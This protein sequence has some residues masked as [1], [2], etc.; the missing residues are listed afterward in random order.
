MSSLPK[1]TQGTGYRIY[2]SVLNK[3][4]VNKIFTH[5]TLEICFFA[6]GDHTSSFIEKLGMDTTRLI[7]DSHYRKDLGVL[8][9]VIRRKGN[10]RESK[11]LKKSG[12]TS[13]YLSVHIRDLIRRN[14]LVYNIFKELYGTYK[15]AFTNGLDYLIFKPLGTEDSP[16]ILNCKIFEPLEVATSLNNP[17]HYVCFVVISSNSN[18]GE[19]CGQLH[20]LLNFDLYYELIQQI[21]CP[22]GK[23]PI[24]KQKKN[25]EVSLLENFNLKMINKELERII[26][27]NPL[28][29]EFQPLRWVTVP[30]KNG[31]VLIFDCRIPYMTS[32][33]KHKH[34]TMYVP[35]SLRPVDNNWYSSNK[36]KELVNGIQNGKVGNWNKRTFKSCNIDEFNWRNNETVLKYANIIT[37]LDTNSFSDH[38]KRIFGLLEYDNSAKS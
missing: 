26:N 5:V 13:L 17:Y 22:H 28:Y 23:Y 19:E 35:V 25:I 32:K 31:D 36:R 15:L 20:L 37:C 16:P 6:L 12:K 33:N 30:V 38:D 1:Y 2:H 18:V 7:C 8:D 14:K 27:S 24:A 9:S 21:I 11:V 34:P 3:E 4:T 29:G 10:S